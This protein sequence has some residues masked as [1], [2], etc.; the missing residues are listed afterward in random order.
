[1]AS[2]LPARHSCNPRFRMRRDGTETRLRSPLIGFQ[3]LGGKRA[4]CGRGIAGIHYFR[5]NIARPGVRQ[6]WRSFPPCRIG[7]M[8]AASALFQETIRYVDITGDKSGNLR[9]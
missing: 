4:V 9:T 3:K 1:M 5:F 7:K 2:S 8:A 6:A